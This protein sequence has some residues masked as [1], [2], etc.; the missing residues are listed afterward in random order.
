MM[1]FNRIA[2]NLYG[3]MKGRERERE[4]EQTFFLQKFSFDSFQN[5]QNLTLFY[6]AVQMRQ[7]ILHSLAF[8][9]G[10]DGISK[11]FSVELCYV[12]FKLSDLSFK[13][14]YLLTTTATKLEC[15]KFFT[16]LAFCADCNRI[17]LCSVF[18]FNC[19]IA[20]KVYCDMNE[21]GTKRGHN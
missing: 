15:F 3:V 2:N 4:V 20:A 6:L 13:S 17:Y 8:H 10:P 11:I 5:S 12:S 21:S 18:R 19:S 9:P 14:T 16:D 7:K 1:S